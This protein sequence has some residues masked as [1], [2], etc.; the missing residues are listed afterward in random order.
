MRI[1]L[2]GEAPAPFITGM[3]GKWTESAR[4]FMRQVIRGGGVR[5][6]SSVSKYNSL[7]RDLHL[8]HHVLSIKHYYRRGRQGVAV[9]EVT[10]RGLQEF[11]G[12]S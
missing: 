7:A 10:E 2:K 4:S 1:S 3:Q 11:G 12:E 8:N 6:V 9:Y 5:H